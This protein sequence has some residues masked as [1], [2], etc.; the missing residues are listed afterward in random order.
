MVE[1]FLAWENF[2]TSTLR[3]LNG[4]RQNNPCQVLMIDLRHDDLPARPK[5]W[6]TLKTVKGKYLFLN[7]ECQQKKSFSIIEIFKISHVILGDYQFWPFSSFGLDQRLEGS[8]TNKNADL[9]KLKTAAEAIFIILKSIK[10]NI[11]EHRNT[12]YIEL[13]RRIKCSVFFLG[14]NSEK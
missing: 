10:L 4:N 14:Q 9:Q 8:V 6:R 3:I 1:N 11:W 13:V 12:S 7:R 5:V 2:F